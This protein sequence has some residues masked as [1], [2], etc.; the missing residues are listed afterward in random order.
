MRNLFKYPDITATNLLKA[1]LNM[2]LDNEYMSILTSNSFDKKQQLPLNYINYD[3]IAGVGAVDVL[4][5][6][7][8]SFESLKNHHNIKKDW[9]FGYLSYDLKNEVE[10]LKSQNHDAF[11][12][13]NSRS[14][15]QL[16]GQ[17]G[18]TNKQVLHYYI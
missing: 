11:G 12:V 2:S 9:F 1:L 8:E 10:D 13:N 4:K 15:G 18:K 5:S 17:G 3:I 6:N 14:D 16:F 7:A